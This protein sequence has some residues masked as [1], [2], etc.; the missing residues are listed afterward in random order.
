MLCLNVGALI[1]GKGFRS[2]RG[3]PRVPLKGL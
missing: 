1:I 2:L 3:F